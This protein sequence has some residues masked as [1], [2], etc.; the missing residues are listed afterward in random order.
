[1]ID[2]LKTI[3]ISAVVVI[4][5]LLLTGNIG[6]PAGVGGT[7]EVTKQYFSAGIDVT[8]TTDVDTLNSTTALNSTGAVDFSNGT[9]STSAT[10]GKT[11][12]TI[13]TNTG[14]TTYVSFRGIGTSATLATS[15]TSCN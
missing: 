13:L 12:W 6:S 9:A 3:G 5:A 14:S 8:G 4:V 15:T 1:M 11:C 2:T 7:Y 10:F